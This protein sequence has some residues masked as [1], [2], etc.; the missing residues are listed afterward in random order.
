MVKPKWGYNYEKTRDTMFF[1]KGWD[2]EE[3]KAML[4]KRRVFFEITLHSWIVR[5]D[6]L[7]DGLLIKTLYK[8]GKGFDRPSTAD[9]I[10]F[11]LKIYQRDRVFFEQT[12]LKMDVKINEK[13][14]YPTIVKILESMKKGE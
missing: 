3:R 13:P 6:I 2:T 8:R 9:Q 14:L 7:G 10:K 4:C 12:G 5:H 1:P 11:D